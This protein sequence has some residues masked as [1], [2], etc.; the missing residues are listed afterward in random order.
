MFSNKHI[1]SSKQYSAA[2][3]LPLAK[4]DP[5]AALVPGSALLGSLFVAVLIL[6]ATSRGDETWGA[7]ERRLL[8]IS[9][10]SAGAGAAACLVGLNLEIEPWALVVAAILALLSVG[11]FSVAVRRPGAKAENGGLLKWA[12]KHRW[13]WLYAA[14]VLV[15][16]ATI[17]YV[18]L[19]LWDGAQVDP[20]VAAKT[21]HVYLTCGDGVCSVNECTSPRPCGKRAVG[22]LEEEEAVEIQCQ[23]RGGRVGVKK[24]SSKIW[25]KLVDG[26]YVT[27]FYIDTPGDGRFTPSIPRC[28]KGDAS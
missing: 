7:G 17:G 13:R 5:S 6:L 18:G 27:D 21:Y 23:T 8:W 10:A 20:A 4:A 28:R 15:S 11:S 22:R 26:N 2:M 12:T 9:A 16:A 14:V 19:R 24:E 1:L 3:A 25:D